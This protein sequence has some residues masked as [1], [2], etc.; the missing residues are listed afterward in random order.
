MSRFAVEAQY[1]L[2]DYHKFSLFCIQLIHNC[3]VASHKFF[4]FH[5]CIVELSK[6]PRRLKFFSNS[7]NPEMINWELIKLKDR[8]YLIYLRW[9][10]NC[11]KLYLP[12]WNSFSLSPLLRSFRIRFN[13]FWLQLKPL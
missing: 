5:D 11:L 9:V 4:N 6:P 2:E 7:F 1:L 12:G 8:C 10:K 3:K 13:P